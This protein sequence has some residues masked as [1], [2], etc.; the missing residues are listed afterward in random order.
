MIRHPNHPIF[1]CQEVGTLLARQLLLESP[2]EK[3]RR[4]PEDVGGIWD[5]SR[6]FKVA[7]ECY[8]EKFHPTLLGIL[9]NFGDGW[10]VTWNDHEWSKVHSSISWT[11]FS[12]DARPLSMILNIDV[13][14]QWGWVVASDGRPSNFNK[15]PKTSLLGA[16]NP[17]F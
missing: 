14:K 6:R 5:S 10:K 1:W 15:H 16:E 8:W 13:S 3:N 12:F 17:P 7:K 11:I 9:D 2:G 4:I